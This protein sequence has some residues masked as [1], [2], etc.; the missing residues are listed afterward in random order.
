MGEALADNKL[1]LEAEFNLYMMI[2]RDMRSTS[3][4]GTYIPILLIYG[5]VDYD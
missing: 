1:L 4:G 2:N 5:K 3:F